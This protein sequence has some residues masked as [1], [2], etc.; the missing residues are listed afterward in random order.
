[1]TLFG[2]DHCK[3]DYV[4]QMDCDCIFFRRSR[5]HDY[6]G[7]M[8]NVFESD[9]SAV[10]VALPI[11]CSE[12]QPFR[13][14]S[15]SIPFRV[16]V[17]CC[18]MNMVKLKTILPLE[19]E[20]QNGQLNLPWH[21]SLDRA[22]LQDKATSYRGGDAQTC[23]FHVPNFRKTDIND[24][25]NILDAAET[26]KMIP[27]QLNKIDLTGRAADWLGKRN[28]DM[29]ILMQGRNV[30]LSKVRRCMA[31]LQAQS[32]KN[33]SAIIIDA[34]S[35]NGLEELYNVAFRQGL[36]HKVTYYRNYILRTPMENIDYATSNLCINPQSIIVHLDLDDALI[37]TDA[38]SK[39]KEAYDKGAD[40]TV[41]SMLRTDKQ[42]EYQVTFR[43]P[44]A[45]RGGNVWQHLRTYRK[46]IYDAV[47]KEYFKVDG[48]WVRH[49]EDWAL[50]I[51]IVELAKNPVEIKDKIYFYEPS[52]DKSQRNV[53]DREQL[54]TK[55]MAKPSLKRLN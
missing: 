50:M 54:I 18:L 7:Q 34:N 32:F 30:T 42:K 5:A 38:L 26:G 47:P 3:G 27:E 22:I 41:G 40:V 43:N 29:V 45:N 33:W 20:I 10:S 46:Y 2:L 15:G 48:E 36:G 23:F 12:P 35:S 49:S 24:W 8:I 37:G 51:P 25:M 11:P 39:V 13:K 14:T 44:R 16:E 9:A 21:R 19:N 17:R 53:Q 28:E 1:M 4:L 6:L 31:S 52:E 55:I